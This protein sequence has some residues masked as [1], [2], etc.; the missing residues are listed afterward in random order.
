MALDNPFTDP[1]A[2]GQLDGAGSLPNGVSPDA[3]FQI[4]HL[5]LVQAGVLQ[6]QNLDLSQVVADGVRIGA[7]L[8]LPLRITGASGSPVRPILIGGPAR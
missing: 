2:S 3:P 7:L 1:V 4:H 6:I 5:N 8:V